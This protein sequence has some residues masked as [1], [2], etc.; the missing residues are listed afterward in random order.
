MVAAWAAFVLTIPFMSTLL[1]H[2][3]GLGLLRAAR[4]P[5]DRTL[6]RIS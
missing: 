1:P 2:A 6:L 5:G 3:L 4:R